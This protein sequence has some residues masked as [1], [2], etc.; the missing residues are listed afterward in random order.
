MPV[1]VLGLAAITWSGL[2]RAPVVSDAASKPQSSAQRL[3]Q[4]PGTTSAMVE[5]DRR[6]LRVR[7]EDTLGVAISNARVEVLKGKAEL[8]P[9]SHLSQV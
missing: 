8:P 9:Q 5:E 3:M 2:H 4:S 7:V 6:T 1:V